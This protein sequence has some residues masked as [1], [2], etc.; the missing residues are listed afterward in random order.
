MFMIVWQHPAKPPW[1]AAYGA[2]AP[3]QEKDVAVFCGE[4]AKNSNIFEAPERSSGLCSR[5]A[6][7]M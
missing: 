1:A 6:G 5:L 4:A 3:H 7:G 2:A